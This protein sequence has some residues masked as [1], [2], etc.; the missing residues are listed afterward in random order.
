[1]TLMYGPIYSYGPIL[2]MA[3]A[4]FHLWLSPPL[5]AKAVSLSHRITVPDK[6]SPYIRYRMA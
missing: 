5:M 1:M 3:M 2:F 4:L 6:T